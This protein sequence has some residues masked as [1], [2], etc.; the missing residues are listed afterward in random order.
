M[1]GYTS[2][3]E[4]VERIKQWWAENGRAVIAGL[5]L[6]IGG[7]L[8]WRGWVSYQQAQAEAASAI[9]GRMVESVERGDAVSAERHAQSLL[10]S[11]TGTPYA[12]MAG[13]TL[14]RVHHQGGD[15][16]AAASDYRRVID[17]AG[18]HP[19]AWVARL[20]LAR[21]LVD[22][23]RLAEALAVLQQE[24]PAPYVAAYEE[25]KGDIYRLQG[26]P[27]QARDAYLRARLAPQPVA[28]PAALEMKLNDL[29]PADDA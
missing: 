26:E 1:E 12:L 25:L 16:D 15:Y 24:P 4:Q 9:Y 28:D 27:E 11:Y 7:L 6:G 22:A 21:T 8:G 29:G 2:D 19:L 5:V 3:D 17:R 14:G 23:D 20:R 13:L 18:E 10:G